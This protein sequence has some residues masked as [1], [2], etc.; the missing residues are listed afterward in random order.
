MSALVAALIVLPLLG[1][2]S[3]TAISRRISPSDAHRVTLTATG[4][5]ALCTLILLPHTGDGTS[6]AME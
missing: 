3:I 6:V 5:T 2:A 4:L 1:S